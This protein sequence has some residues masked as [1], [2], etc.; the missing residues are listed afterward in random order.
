MSFKSFAEIEGT[1]FDL[2]ISTWWRTIY[3]LHR[4]EAA[5]Y[6]YFVQSIESWFYPD[7]DAAVRNLANSTYQFGLP[8]I[9]EAN[10]IHAHLKDRFGT[11]AYLVKN[12]CSKTIYRADGPAESPRTE[13]R[14]R[15]LVEGPLGVDFKNIAR[16]I[17]LL[18]KTIADEIWL[19]TISPI[20]SYPGVKRVFSRVPAYDCARI[21][22]SCDV[23]VKLSYVEGMFGPPLEMFHCGGTAVVYDVT[24]HDEYI[25]NHENALVIPSGDEAS[26]IAAVNELKRQ[27]GLLARLKQ[28]ALA[29]AANWPDWSEV[30]PQFHRALVAIVEKEPRVARERLHAMT[31]E[32]FGQY[33]RAENEIASASRFSLS[34]RLA[35]LASRAA[36]AVS[37][38]SATAAHVLSVAHARL[39]E[40]RRHPV[41]RSKI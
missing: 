38:R 41:R 23:L 20:S 40:E 36:T 14:M 16:T 33:V 28:G 17:A 4:V 21:Y 32:V 15:V 3:D 24:G 5:Q 25:S 39:I 10:W 30:S 27:P 7:H 13:G 37:R 11:N 31:R 8:T 19:L 18:R 2:A 12:G 34:K 22:R 1:R 9:T 6:C 29:T 26:V 35:G